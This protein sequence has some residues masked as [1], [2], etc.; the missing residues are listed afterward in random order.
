M[1]KPCCGKLCGAK[2]VDEG[3]SDIN[4]KRS[5]TDILCLLLFIVFLV[6]V[7]V[8]AIVGLTSGNP[9][10]LMYGTDY[11]GNICYG[12]NSNNGDKQVDHYTTGKKYVVY[13]RMTADI[14]AQK[15]VLA[16]D[17][18]KVKFFGI[19]RKSC[20]VQNEWVCTED[21]LEKDTAALN[22]C[23][24]E[25]GG[26][27]FASVFPFASQTCSDLMKKCFKTPVKTFEIMYRCIAN[28]TTEEHN[29]TVI[30]DDPTSLSSSDDG[31]IVKKT[32]YS[33]TKIEP[34]QKDVVAEQLSSAIALVGLYV[35]D[36]ELS[37]VQILVCGCV[38]SVIFGFL[39]LV[40]L[41]FFA[42][43]MIWTTLIGAMII[44]IA[45]SFF[46]LYKAQ[47]IELSAAG[48]AVSSSVADATSA[49]DTT[50]VANDT[51][52][53]IAYITCFITTIYI[54]I[55]FVAWKKIM[56]AAA[57]IV[58]ATKAIRDMPVIV[59][60]P[61]STVVTIL[62]IFVGWLYCFMGLYTIGS[63]NDVTIDPPAA[64]AS[65][66]ANFTS[67]MRNYE[68]NQY[69]DYIIGYWVFSLLWISNFILGV[70]IMTICG[71]FAE[72][73]WTQGLERMGMPIARSL[74][75][76]VRYHLGTVAFGSLLIAIVQFIRLFLEY[77]DSQTKKLQEKNKGLKYV[78]VCL[79]CLVACFERCVK[80][81]TR[82]AYI[83]VAIRGTGFCSAGL[84]VFKLLSKHGAQIAMTTTIAA[85]L[86]FL[87]KVVIMGACGVIG[88]LW[89]DGLAGLSSPILPVICILV[90][91][92][93]VGS[94]FLHVY[95]L[96]IETIL[97]SYCIDLDEN[98]PPRQY[99]F[100]NSLA[101]AAGQKVVSKIKHG[102]HPN[103]I[104]KKKSSGGDTTSSAY[105]VPD[106]ASEESLDFL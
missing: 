36:I 65:S 32:Q 68:V 41:R 21:E 26:G 94:A 54:V 69:R 82:N 14:L 18:T 29:K 61:L 31:C 44:M 43:C 63:Y 90:L 98:K 64:I 23:L 71:A 96:G 73:Y 28:Y 24:S 75:R 101:K 49:V 3:L 89:L 78:M 12:K 30:C 55:I 6:S 103:E 100:S 62:G 38:A 39:W 88:F 99:K 77:I 58:E 48:S 33:V 81:L 17:P 4:R 5:C 22:Q 80:Y 95:D 56:V 57:I 53:P 19:C 85:F 72:W 60:F 74:F 2:E 52:T 76:T 13:P 91:A 79:K 37:M 59:A 92:L 46:T 106:D 34:T 83:I 10:S 11:N 93:C 40:L 97:I 45:G 27:A 1:T 9:D 102:A 16:T 105:I 47:I 25:S 67:A 8:L 84:A 87:G 42:R 15:D 7:G 70:A 66:S 51:W 50:S 104:E 86:M 20:P 35:K